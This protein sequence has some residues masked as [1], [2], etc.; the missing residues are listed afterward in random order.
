MK[1][2]HTELQAFINKAEKK[3]KIPCIRLN[4]TSDIQWEYIEYQGK[5]VFDTFPDVQF[6][7]YTK[8]P[9]RKIDGIKNYHLT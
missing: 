6:Y 1:T 5:N 7:D 8:I 9:T 2:L 4:G 3:G